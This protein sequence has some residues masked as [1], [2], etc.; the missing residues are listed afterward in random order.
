LR[1]RLT[2]ESTK[3]T[4][5]KRQEFREGRDEIMQ[6]RVRGQDSDLSGEDRW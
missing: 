6:S 3:A 1:H 5:K 2:T 4:E